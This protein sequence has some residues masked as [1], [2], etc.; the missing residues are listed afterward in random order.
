MTAFSEQNLNK[1]PYFK[2]TSHTNTPYFWQRQ[3]SPENKSTMQ[4][5]D[6]LQCIY[7]KWVKKRQEWLVL[8]SA[9]CTAFDIALMFEH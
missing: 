7:T 1:G 4:I 3:R 5:T 8:G 2:Q 9:K 6:M